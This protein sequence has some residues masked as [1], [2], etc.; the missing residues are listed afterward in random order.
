MSS[1]KEDIIAKAW[2]LERNEP[3]PIEIELP[4]F[5]AKQPD[6]PTLREREPFV[7]PFDQMEAQREGKPIGVRQGAKLVGKSPL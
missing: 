3:S 5:N 6:L 4:V 7:M 1:N 2:R